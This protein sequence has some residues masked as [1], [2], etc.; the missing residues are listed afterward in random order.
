MKKILLA[1]AAMSVLTISSLVA[2]NA[3]ECKKCAGDKDAPCTCCSDAKSCDAK[4]TDAKS[5]DAAK[6]KACCPKS[7]KDAKPATSTEKKS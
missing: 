7:D 4:S 1:L 6:E 3:K 2:D 5:C